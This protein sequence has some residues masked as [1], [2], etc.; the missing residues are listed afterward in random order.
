MDNA[1]KRLAAQR[2]PSGRLRGWGWFPVAGE[3]SAFKIP[4]STPSAAY[5]LVGGAGELQEAYA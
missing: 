1:L 4:I 2:Q 5:P 3:K